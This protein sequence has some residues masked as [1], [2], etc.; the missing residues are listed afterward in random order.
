M[1]KN[2]RQGMEYKRCNKNDTRQRI[3][4]WK[5]TN[6]K[7]KMEDERLKGQNGRPRMEDK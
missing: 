3:Q 6:E 2:G 7:Q 5:T 4:G 1:T